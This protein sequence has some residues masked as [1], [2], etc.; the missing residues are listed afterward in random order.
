MANSNT[1]KIHNR[2][3]IPN[4]NG[5][6]RA[7]VYKNETEMHSPHPD[8]KSFFPDD[9]DGKQVIDPIKGAYG[10]AERIQGTNNWIGKTSGISIRI[11]RAPDG[12]II[13]AFPNY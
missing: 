8:G 12:R 4:S 2:V 9:W 6:Y 13:S 7:K 5:C 11:F 3:E 1:Y 10:N